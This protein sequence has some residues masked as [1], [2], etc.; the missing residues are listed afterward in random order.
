MNAYIYIEGIMHSILSKNRNHNC[1]CSCF[2]NTGLFNVDTIRKWAHKVG[3]VTRKKSYMNK[4]NRGKRFKF[5][6]TIDE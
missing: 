6:K 2:Q 3:R 4:I 1:D 5:G